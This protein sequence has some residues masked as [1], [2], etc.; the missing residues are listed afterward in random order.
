MVEEEHERTG[1]PSAEPNNQDVFVWA[2]YL[3]GGADRDIDVEAVY[4]RSFDLAP[5]RLGWRTHP[6]LPD[7]KKT[8]KALQAVE[9]KTHVGLVQKSGPYARRLTAQGVR[10]VERHRGLLESTY[11]GGAPVAAASTNEHERRRRALKSSASFA[12]WQAGEPFDVSTLADALDC[13]AA[14]PTSVW[15]S[16]ITEVRR[17]ADVLS[18]NELVEFV[19]AAHEFL[20]LTVGSYS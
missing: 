1:A 18:D 14:S 6:D 7:Y 16:R 15:R 20:S 12:S 2:L 17:A 13:N 9:A 8:S 10:W 4:L 19:G 3:L 11:S 5:A